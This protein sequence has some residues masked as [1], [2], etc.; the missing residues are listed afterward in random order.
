MRIPLALALLL[1]PTPLVAQARLLRST[2]VD[3]LPSK[4]AT[5]R[6][7]YGKDTLQFGDLRLPEGRGPF[8]VAIVIHGG[9]WLS[10][11]SLVNSTPLAD[12]LRDQGI[13]TWNIEYRRIGNPGGGWP[14][15]FTDVAEA[16]EYLRVLARRYPLD[17]ARVVAVGHSAGGHLAMWLAGAAKVPRASPVHR[18]DPLPLKGVIALAGIVDLADFRIYEENSCGHVV[19]SFIGGAPE[20][21]PD[22]YQAGSPVNLLPLSAPTVQIVGSLDRV[23]PERARNAHAA[24]AK[25]SGSAFELIVLEGLGHHEPMAPRGTAWATV[26]S[27]VRRAL[28]V[29]R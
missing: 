22:R 4:P 1:A 16:A 2:D 9:C 24:A 7:F 19:D 27:A 5:E 12:A 29:E 25:A 23:M 28:G 17:L 15:T 18:A 6:V 14:G 11:Y 8:P 3:T 26:S 21:V 20:A 10:R 13:A